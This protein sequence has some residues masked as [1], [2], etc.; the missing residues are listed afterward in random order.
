M[1]L[2]ITW[3]NVYNRAVETRFKKPKNPK[4]FL[5]FVDFLFSNQ[6]FYFF[7]SNSV[8]LFELIG[9]AIIS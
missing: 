1:S 2:I 9:V 5:G 8:N 7:V 3:Q 6:N 4:Q